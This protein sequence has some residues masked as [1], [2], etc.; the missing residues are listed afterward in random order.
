MSYSEIEYSTGWIVVPWSCRIVVTLTSWV[1]IFLLKNKYSTRFLWNIQKFSVNFSLVLRCTSNSCCYSHSSSFHSRICKVIFNSVEQF[2]R[3]CDHIYSRHVLKNDIWKQLC[4]V[5]VQ[6]FVHHWNCFRNWLATAFEVRTHFVI[7]VRNLCTKLFNCYDWAGLKLFQVKVD[8]HCVCL[9]S[10]RKRQ[11][12]NFV[13]RGLASF[14][15]S[16][17][18]IMIKLFQVR[19]LSASFSYSRMAR[20]R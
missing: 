3:I 1:V 11:H 18:Q 19:T 2:S 13:I 5:L 12:F 14:S 8:Q 20:D 16:R 7:S 17:M 6:F 15:Y 4:F 10:S 9:F